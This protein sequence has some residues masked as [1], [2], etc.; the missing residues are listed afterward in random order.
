MPP[1][2]S[3]EERLADLEREQLR[4]KTEVKPILDFYSAGTIIG[5]LLVIVGGLIVGA[6]TVWAAIS[7]WVSSH[8][9]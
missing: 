6:A 7:G 3:Y 4:I 5:K 9:K 8:W 2:R 1:H